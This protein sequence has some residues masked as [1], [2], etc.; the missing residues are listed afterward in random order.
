LQDAGTNDAVI[1]S[2]RGVPLDKYT[3]NINHFVSSLASPASDYYQPEAQILLITPQP[4][5]QAMRDQA[6]NKVKLDLEHTRRYKDTCLAIGREWNE[7]TS[8][9]VQILD[10]WKLLVDAA[11]DETDEALRPYFVDGVHLSTKAY[12]LLFD[13]IMRIIR[14]RWSHLDPEKMKMTVPRYEDATDSWD[15]YHP[16]PPSRRVRQSAE[17]KLKNS[18]GFALGKDAR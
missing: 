7:K 13:E 8:G 15:W 17:V 3:A 6:G 1:G 16:L 14:S 12:R 11:G 18:A 9:K 4:F 5:V 2:K 10:Y